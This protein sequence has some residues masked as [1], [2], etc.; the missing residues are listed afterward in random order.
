LAEDHVILDGVT[1]SGNYLGTYIGLTAL[2]R[3]WWVRA[4]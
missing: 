4:R 1:G 3:Y 2:E